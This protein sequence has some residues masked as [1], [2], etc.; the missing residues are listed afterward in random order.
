MGVS[1]IRCD[2]YSTWNLLEGDAQWVDR[3]SYDVLLMVASRGMTSLR[4]IEGQTLHEE[5]EELS[6]VH[7]N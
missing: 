1:L 6:V 4:Q 5:L 3:C 2:H 7:E